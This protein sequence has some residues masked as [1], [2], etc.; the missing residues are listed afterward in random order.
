[1]T[2]P[3]LDQFVLTVRNLSNMSGDNREINDYL[4]KQTDTLHKYAANLDT[5]LEALDVHENSL[6]VITILG[7]KTT[8]QIPADIPA[9][10]YHTAVA[11]Q[12]NDFINAVSEEELRAISEQLANVMKP[13]LTNLGDV[14]KPMSAIP[15]I[16]NAISKLQVQPYQLT[17]VHSL[18]CQACLMSNNLKPALSILD[19]DIY[20]LG[21]EEPGHSFDPK[22]FLSY[23]YLGG[24]IYTAMK[25]FP[26]AITFYEIALTTLLPIMSQIM[27][28]SYKKYVLVT[29]VH[30]GT[31]PTLPKLSPPLIERVLKPVCQAYL[32]IIP[33]YQSGDSAE[34]QRIITKYEDVYQR[35]KNRGLVRQVVK[36]LHRKNILRLTKTFLNMSIADLAERVNLPSA[37]EAEEHLITMIESGEI[38]A[39]INHKDGTVMFSD[40]PKKYEDPIVLKKILDEITSKIAFSNTVRTMD[41]A[42]TTNPMF[43]KKTS[44]EEDGLSIGGQSSLKSYQS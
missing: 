16:K 12:I 32:D 22:Y 18:L 31:V 25:N 41:E 9:V 2:I 34:L 37:E 33:A 38:N 11:S 24:V 17:E 30:L 5:V 20:I 43:V 19:Q 7:V 1:M 27:I 40:A 29:I 4:T 21:T 36:A 35:D 44:T 8:A 39:K 28:E 13:M 15:I 14:K 10:Q 3:Q 26:R 23:Y 6:T 42:I